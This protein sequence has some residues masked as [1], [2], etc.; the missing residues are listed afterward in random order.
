[1]KKYFV[2]LLGLVLTSNGVYSQE[3]KVVDR[4]AAIVGS[5][6][7]L[8]SDVDREYAQ[9][10]AQGAPEDERLKCYILQQQLTQKLLAQQAAIDSIEV[11]EGELDDNINSRMRYMTSQ[12]GGQDRLERFLNRSLLQYKEEIRPS[13][14]EQLKANRMQQTIIQ[15]IDVTPMEVKRFFEAI[16]PDSLPY[17]GTEVEL[18]EIVIFPS[19]TREEKQQ[20]RERA[21]SLRKQVLDGTDFATVAR[22]YSDDKGSAINGGD[23]GFSTRDNFVKEFSAVAF[24]MKPGE[25]SQVFESEFGFHFLQVL[26][27]R[28]EEVKTRHVLVNIKPTQNS[29]NRAKSKIDSIYQLVVSKKVD[30]YTAATA[31]SDNQETKFNGGMMLNMQNQQSR[32]TLIPAKQLGADLFK[33]IDTLEVGEYSLPHQFTTE[34]GQKIGFRFTFLKS[35]TE[36]HKA[37]YD[38][39]FAKLKEMAMTDKINRKL[40]EWFEGRR[41][42]TYIH[43]NESFNNCEELSI[44]INT[45]PQNANK[46]EEKT[47]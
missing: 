12:A 37:N 15:G 27:R 30:F 5:A 32:T 2:A 22:L 10:L 45:A 14:L 25:I 23:L 16:H 9:N 17:F 19:L 24:R 7:I 47:D 3:S 29:L 18:G 26:E 44:W 42:V 11:S 36:P 13:V 34:R 31:Y 46:T 6:I 1:M 39:D 8:Q 41:K 43:I 28:G 4:V 40:S 20:Y 33:A 21:E 38:Q 35:R